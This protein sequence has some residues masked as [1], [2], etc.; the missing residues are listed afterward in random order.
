MSDAASID[1]KCK[2][3]LKSLKGG[4]DNGKAI[5]DKLKSYRP[6]NAEVKKV[7]KQ[8]QDAT[9]VIKMGKFGGLKT[10]GI[11]LML[12]INSKKTQVKGVLYDWIAFDPKTTSVVEAVKVLKSTIEYNFKIGM[13]KDENDK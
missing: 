2:L 3:K 13:F 7:L 5:K 11:R 8:I 4:S 12:D 1:T 6:H 9:P 10:M